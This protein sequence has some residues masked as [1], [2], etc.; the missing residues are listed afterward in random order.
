MT[1]AHYFW[2]FNGKP[3]KQ[4]LAGASKANDLPE[5]ESQRWLAGQMESVT[6]HTTA[7]LANSERKK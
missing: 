7:I 6:E 4:S 5:G 2:K 1:M 3:R